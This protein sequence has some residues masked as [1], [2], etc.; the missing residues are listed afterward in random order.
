MKTSSKIFFFLILSLSQ[1]NAQK[2]ILGYWSGNLK[3]LSIEL[4][5]Q[6][7]VSK[8]KKSLD[9][10]ISIPSQKVSE[11]KLPVFTYKK[12]QIHFELPSSAGIAKFDGKLK[13]DSIIGILLQAVYVHF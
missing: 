2:E 6:I 1:I 8:T 4:D 10:L 11:Y 13:A 7:K 3:M 9:G 12:N 5:F